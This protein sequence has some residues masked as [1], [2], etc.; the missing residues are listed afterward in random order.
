MSTLKRLLAGFGAWTAYDPAWLV[1]LARAQH[2]GK[3]WLAEALARCT[4]ARG[5]GTVYVRFVSHRNANQPGA[6]WQFERSVEL[7]D[8]DAGVVLVDVLQDGRIGGVELV[9][10]EMGRPGAGGSASR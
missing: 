10:L 4:Q 3:P 6:A 2:P 5:A 7:V 1:A 9:D 8:R